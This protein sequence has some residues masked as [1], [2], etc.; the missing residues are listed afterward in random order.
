VFWQR[1]GNGL[2]RP[3]RA[4]GVRHSA[5]PRMKPQKT[6][7]LRQWLIHFDGCGKKYLQG[8]RSDVKPHPS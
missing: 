3:G 2:A 1:T 5:A 8:G 7:A 4:E 6:N